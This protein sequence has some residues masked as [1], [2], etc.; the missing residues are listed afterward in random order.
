MPARNR[1]RTMKIESKLA[2]VRGAVR[3][4]PVT[5]V[6]D[7]A[8]R[9]IESTVERTQTVSLRD[10]DRWSDQTEVAYYESCHDRRA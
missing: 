2:L 9:F 7:T 6:I 4:L 8:R 3:K 1:L 5:G 10:I